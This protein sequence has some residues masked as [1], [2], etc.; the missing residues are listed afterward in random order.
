METPKR[1][2]GLAGLLVVSALGL[3]WQTPVGAP[4]TK[5]R[6]EDLIS[7]MTLEEKAGQLSLVTADLDVTGPSIRADYRE[8]IRQGRT[9]AVFNAFGATFTRELQR[10]AVEESRLGIPLLFGYDVI[11]G[12]RTIFPIPLAEAAS[13]DLEAIERSARIA[14]VEA[15]AA[16][17]HW[18][19]APMVDVA[20]DPRWGRIAEGA[21]EDV[22]LGGRVAV[23]RVHGFQGSDL[24]RPDTILACAK[25]FAAYGAAEAGRDY[26]TV[27]VSE[28]VLR[29]VYLPPFKAAVDAGVATVMTAFNEWDGVPASAN[30]F[31]LRRVLRQEWGFGGFVVSDY[32]SIAEL[33][34]HGVAANPAQAARLALDAGVDMD[35]QSGFYQL[36]PGLVRE[37]K[38]ETAQ[39][40]EAVRRV[41][42]IKER[43][44]L[45]DSPYAYSNEEREKASTLTEE[46]L[47]AARDMARKS[48]VLL[49]NDGLL[50][51]DKSVRKLALIGPLADDRVDLIGSWSAAGDPSRAVTLREGFRQ[52][53]APESELLYAKGCA[54]DGEDRSG[55]E[56][57]LAAARQADVVVLAVGEAAS[58]SGEA[59]S[60]ASLGLPGVQLELLRALA[61]TG[62]PIAVVLMNGRPLTLVEVDETA[63]AVVEAWFGGLQAGPAVAD[64]LLGDWNPSGRLPA[65]FPRQIGQIP[66]YY[67]H[68]QTGRPIDPANKYTSKYLDVSNEPLYPFGFGL[69][70]TQF[71]Y[72]DPEIDREALG[73]DDTL[74]VRVAVKNTGERA[75]RET[76]QLYVQDLVGSVTRPVKEL[77][78]FQQ[79]TLGP[80]EEV[81]VRFTLRGQDLA[82]YRRDL[83]FGLEPGDYRV[84]VGPNSRDVRE[85]RFRL[86]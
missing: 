23:A 53:L 33:I 34:P 16:G 3:G 51:L 28:R 58:M 29:E 26:N 25:H 18:T 86:E 84:W 27:D 4:P 54:I 32:T 75:G 14:A 70:Y 76:V 20:R 49:K 9:G 36:L 79:V 61:A 22:Y 43:L 65:T 44:G 81:L 11:H 73:P 55:F 46:H 10:Q 52:A 69:G 60:R 50:P 47:E 19:F 63:N 30:A 82:F 80:G 67:S 78:G 66:L 35:M 48:I 71:E 8:A 2:A 85:V 38:V 1:L 5:N 83:S 74:E 45:F 21:G 57:A 31:L 39:L 62:R 56:E 12:H 24:A 41:L 37:G 6:V 40:D 68:K 64:V 72:G 42:R 7:R 13:W 77:K 15:S 17:L 59:A